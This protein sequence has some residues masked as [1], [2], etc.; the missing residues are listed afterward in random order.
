MKT[1][2]NLR[3]KIWLYLIV[4]SL[5]ILI[6]L[7]LFQVIFLNG[8]YK[9]YKTK[10]LI[11]TAQNITETYNEE[12]YEAM[13][14]DIS[15]RDSAC[16]ELIKN[17]KLVYVSNT[18]NKGC[19]AN[20]KEDLYKKDF[21]ESDNTSARYTLK[22]PRFNNETLVLAFKLDNTTH[23]FVSASLEPIDATVTILR[24]QLF[25]ITLIVIILSLV[26]SYFISRII[27][28]PIIKMKNKAKELAHGNY[29]ITFENSDIEEIN[30]LSKTLN[31]ACNELEK[32]E[33]LRRELMANV[34]H[35]LKTPLTMIKAYAELIRDVTHKDKEKMNK[36]LNTII[37]ET[38]RLN[39]LVNDILELSKIRSNSTPLELEEFDL[40]ELIKTIINRYE[41]YI[42]KENYNIE[43]KE[44]PNTIIKAD[45]KRIEQVIY[46]LVNNAINYT[47]DDKKVII[48]IKEEKQN[49]KVEIKDTGK[50][51][52]KKDL[53]YIWDK[54][55]KVD[56][57]HS[58]VQVGSGIGLS[59]VKNILIS[60]NFEY[61][62]ETK[63]NKGTTFYFI[64]PKNDQNN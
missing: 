44:K 21:I 28:N 41:I 3:Y 63:I 45:K 54:Y 60:H 11:N 10:E 53:E 4:F 16:I 55:Y 35:D 36:N 48:N 5:S 2:S 30:E 58:R 51:I 38:D 1:K 26:V 64:I 46:N 59:I 19:M 14:D 33:D 50:G 25:Y 7:W 12:N 39:I 40:N 62:V 13:L 20:A 31:Y 57:T 47:G 37:E 8:Y 34:S 15:H 52:N 42:E 61:G 9:W 27:S 23:L 22:N 29:N 17:N 56:K 18:F 43:Y 49:I 6:L 32:T 24:S